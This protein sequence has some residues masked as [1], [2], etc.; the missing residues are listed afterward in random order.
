MADQ[1]SRG[2]QKQDRQQPATAARQQGGTTHG[3]GERS[4]ADKGQDQ[5]SNP[6]AA[7]RQATNEQR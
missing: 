2:G 5:Q 6:D 7:R 3:A 4:G 1:K